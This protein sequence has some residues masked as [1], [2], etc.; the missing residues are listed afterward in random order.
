MIGSEVVSLTSTLDR[1]IHAQPFVPPSTKS[2]HSCH[3]SNV[4]LRT[5][6]RHIL[7][8]QSG[9][10]AFVISR[11]CP[12]DGQLHKHRSWYPRQRNIDAIF[13]QYCPLCGRLHQNRCAP[14]P[15]RLL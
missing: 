10:A 14:L 1:A 3:S 13:G 6:P 7:P 8:M 12:P 15:L 9:V 2:H 11:H 5:L 4:T